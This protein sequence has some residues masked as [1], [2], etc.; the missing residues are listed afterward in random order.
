MEYSQNGRVWGLCRDL[1]VSMLYCTM[2]S[3][4]RSRRCARYFRHYLNL[5]ILWSVYSQSDLIP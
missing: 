2:Y 5:V 4:L 1:D 3:D